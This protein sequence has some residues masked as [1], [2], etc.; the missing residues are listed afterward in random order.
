[1]R[2][3]IEI[4]GVWPASY[5]GSLR[6]ETEGSRDEA[7]GVAGVTFWLERN[8]ARGQP[9]KAMKTLPTP[10]AIELR[11][12]LLAAYPVEPAAP[13]QVITYKVEKCS[14][15]SG[16]PDS[17]NVVETRTNV[18][19]DVTDYVARCDKKQDAER[20]LAALEAA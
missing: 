19:Q 5:P 6:L 10:Q 15:W 9:V 20:V 4:P 13:K 7:H 2:K 14:S 11:D 1:M 16:Y 18:P 12:F 17:W 3:T 8:D